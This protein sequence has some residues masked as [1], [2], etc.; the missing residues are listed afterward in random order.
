[1]LR[2]IEGLDYQRIA[3]SL[4]ININTVR[5]RLKRAREILMTLGQAQFSIE[6]IKGQLGQ[7]K[8][9]LIKKSRLGQ[10]EVANHGM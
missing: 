1:V 8:S 5:S 4:G 2:E 9:P 3:G 10:E 7:S 6:K